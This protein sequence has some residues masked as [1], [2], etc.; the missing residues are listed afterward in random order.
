MKVL[1]SR[2]EII[3]KVCTKRGWTTEVETGD[4]GPSGFGR[5]LAASLWDIDSSALRVIIIPAAIGTRIRH[6]KN[7]CLNLPDF[8]LW[9]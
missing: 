3:L 7:L 8:D 1:L 6:E 2:L 4:G 9:P 5:V